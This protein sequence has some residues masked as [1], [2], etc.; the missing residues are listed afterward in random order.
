MKKLNL[1][2][3]LLLFIA[4]FFYQNSMGQTYFTETFDGSWVGSNPTIAPSGWTQVA[5]VSGTSE[6]NW[7][8]ATN[9]GSST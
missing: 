3:I 9:T 6:R 2:S 1:L 8:Q 5:G 7:D 4:V